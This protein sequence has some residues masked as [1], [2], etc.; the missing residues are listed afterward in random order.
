MEAKWLLFAN[1][2]KMYQFK[3]KKSE[4]KPCWLCF[5]NILKAFTVKN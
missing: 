4:I 5:G 1:S 2:L 3:A